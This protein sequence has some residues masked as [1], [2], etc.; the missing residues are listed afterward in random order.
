METI[1]IYDTIKTI[2]FS[3]LPTI[4]AELAG[5][6]FYGVTTKDGTHCAVI[7]LPNRAQERLSWKDAMKWASEVGGALPSR[8][9][10]ALL[11]ANAKDQFEPTWHWTSDTLDA[12]TGNKEDASFAW[13]CVFHNGYQDLYHESAAGGARAVRMIPLVL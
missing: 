11:Y 10:S 4:G 9:V 6:K 1:V 5:G 2:S 7:L 3:T 8:P 12:D 13:N